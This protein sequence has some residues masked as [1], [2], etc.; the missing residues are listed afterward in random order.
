MTPHTITDPKILRKELARIRKQGWAQ[1]V[2]ELVVGGSGI[3]APV[4]GWKNSQVAALAV[5]LPTSR[6]PE[7]V[8]GRYIRLLV[9]AAA[10]ISNALTTA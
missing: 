10:E 4:M 2:D 9:A 3:A 1:S 6:F 5:V 7:G 8:R